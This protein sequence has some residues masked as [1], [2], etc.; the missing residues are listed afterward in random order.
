MIGGLRMGYLWDNERYELA[1]FGRNITNQQQLIGGIDFNNLT[2]F[3]N[4]NNERLVGVQFKA[5]F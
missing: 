5:R 4:D 2:G 1:V 3:V